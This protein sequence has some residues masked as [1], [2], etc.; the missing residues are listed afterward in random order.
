M[1]RINISGLR[2]CYQK[3]ILE[4]EISNYIMENG[5]VDEIVSGGSEGVDLFAKEYA[6]ESEINHMEF[7]PDWQ[8]HI[9][10]ASFKGCMNS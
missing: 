10:V 7:L 5:G 4:T 3:N 2:I 9:N 8:S 1:K 6:Q